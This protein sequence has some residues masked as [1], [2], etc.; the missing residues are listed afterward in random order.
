MSPEN[1]TIAPA[2]TLSRT[3]GSSRSPYASRSISRPLPRSCRT[4][5]PRGSARVCSSSRETSAVKPDRVKLER[6]T[7]RMHRVRGLKAAR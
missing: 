5:R 3:R 6:C 1:T 7:F 2:F 4:G